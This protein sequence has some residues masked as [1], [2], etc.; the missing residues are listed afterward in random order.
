MLYLH[1]ALREWENATL[2]SYTGVF[3]SYV[4]VWWKGVGEAAAAAAA[5]VLVFY[6]P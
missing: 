5:A 6:V 2:P 1:E 3:I 4:V